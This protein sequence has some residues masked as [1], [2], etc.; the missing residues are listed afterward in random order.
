MSVNV[1]PS[2]ARRRL[3]GAA[4]WLTTPLL[5]DDYLGHVN[6][7]WSTGAPRGRVEAVL[8]E[9]ADSATVWIRP[10][11][12]WVAHRPGQY[13]RVGVEVDGVRHWRTYSLTS[14]PARADGRIAIT[15]KVVSDGLVSTHLVRRVAR[16][17]IVRLAPPAGEYVL[18][19]PLPSRLLFVTAGSGITPVMG[20]LRDLVARD[21]LPDVALVHIAPTRDAVIFGAE[22]RRLARRHAGLCLHEHHD[23][24][25]GRFDPSI[26]DAICADW[27]E[28]PAWACGPAGLLDALTD[29]WVTS[30]DPERLRLERFRPVV[31][32]AGAVG[33]GGR[34][35]FSVSGREV[36]ADGATP[37]L[38]VGEEAGALLPSGCRMGIC[39]SCVGRLRCG[40]VRDLRTGELRDGEGELVR[41]CVSAAAGPVEIEL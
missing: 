6:P 5:P 17:T 16:G 31:A 30:G 3:V 10:G 12:G 38:V 8:P 7:L 23:A 24:V 25:E 40:A 21:A 14:V 29:H 9:T 32:A 26:L 19:D 39:H 34:V 33:A 37:L 18:P 41:T 4:R 22:L 2:A 1:L 27:R 11:V 28:R 35:R 13:V 15:V 36:D 20:M